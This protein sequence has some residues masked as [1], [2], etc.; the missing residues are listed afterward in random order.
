MKKHTVLQLIDTINAG[1]AEVLAVNT[2]NLFLN[3]SDISSYLVTTRD[4]GTLYDLIKDRN[5][6][7]FINKKS[8]LDFIFISRMIRFV[9]KNEITIVH[10]HTT[11]FFAAFLLKIFLFQ[12]IKLIWHNHTGAYT[13]LKGLKFYAIKFCSFYFDAII[14]VNEEL[15]DWG[16]NK[17]YT[18]RNFLIHNFPYFTDRS[19]KTTLSGKKGK[20]IVSIAGLRPEKDHRTLLKAFLYI[21]QNNSDW[22]LHLVGKDYL[23]NYAKDIHSFISENNLEQHVYFYGMKTDIEYILSQ[24]DIGVVSSKSEGLPLAL[25]EY[26]LSKTA[27]VTT[28]VGQCSK[29]LENN[30]FVVESENPLAL[31]KSIEKLIVD[32][33]LRAS[34]GERFYHRVNNHYGVEKYFHS[35]REIYDNE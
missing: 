35:L 16:K 4:R 1:G 17:L 10:A 7:E 26:G 32:I 2:H 19:K 15:L 28:D 11:S 13:Q 31:F 30:E 23:D 18:K 29:V 24:V 14:H 21:L 9:K 25:L 6:Y 22:T 20:R 12:K 8:A 27:T 33:Q 5:K 34:E 3:D